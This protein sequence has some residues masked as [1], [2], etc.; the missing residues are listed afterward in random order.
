[1]I[2]RFWPKKNWLKRSW[3]S[4]TVVEAVE[5]IGTETV[6]KTWNGCAISQQNYQ[7]RLDSTIQPELIRSRGTSLRETLS[8][9]VNE[10]KRFYTYVRSY[11]CRFGH[12]VT[13]NWMHS[14]GT[15][16]GTTVV[17]SSSS[18]SSSTSKSSS[19]E[20]QAQKTWRVYQSLRCLFVDESKSSSKW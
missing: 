18:K 12:F 10:S 9:W 4:E 5:A 6:L 20:T 2:Q 17:S 8:R 3:L 16:G 1:M 14:R 7:L 11:D 13:Y 15:S 19:S